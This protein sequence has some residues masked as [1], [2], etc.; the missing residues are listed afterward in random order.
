MVSWKDERWWSGGSVLEREVMKL[1]RFGQRQ[2]LEQQGLI[3][4]LCE[5]QM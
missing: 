1:V 2:G 5:V 3:E 4:I